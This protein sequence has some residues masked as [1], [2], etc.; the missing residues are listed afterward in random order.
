MTT[1]KTW[2]QKGQ[3]QYLAIF[4]FDSWRQ[5]ENQKEIIVCDQR[6]R[7]Q[8][9]HK[10]IFIFTFMLAARNK[11]LELIK[12]TDLCCILRQ[13]KIWR[14]TVLFKRNIIEMYC[15]DKICDCPTTQN[16]RER[17]RVSSPLLVVS[18]MGATFGDLLW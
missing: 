13:Y 1:A 6:E 2:K 16:K 5:S 8:T 4:F 3:L 9:T 12:R 11:Y 17:E 10:T 18:L 7:N 15:Q 14:K